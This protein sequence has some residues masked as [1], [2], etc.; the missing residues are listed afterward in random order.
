[1]EHCMNASIFQKNGFSFDRLL[2]LIALADAGSI[3]M[4]AGRDP[5]RQSQ[6]SRQLKELETCFG[7][8]L[9]EHKGRQV[10]LTP[11]GQKLVALA[12]QSFALL[13]GFASEAQGQ[14]I[15]YRLGAGDALLHWALAPVLPGITHAFPR[16]R[17][18][19]ESMET[20]K[21]I[22]AVSTGVLDFGVVRA[23]AALGQLEHR[24]IGSLTYRLYVPVP[25]MPDGNT[26]SVKSLLTTLPL[27]FL[28]G[29]GEYVRLLTEL[30]GN[31]LDAA[32]TYA[33]L[34]LVCRAVAS[35]NCIGVLPTLARSELPAKSFYEMN[36]SAL[37]K[38]KRPLALVYHPRILCVRDDGER[39]VTRLAHEIRARLQA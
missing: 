24:P 10:V 26:D 17:F 25:L 39:L 13:E 6:Y 35:A 20:E 3:A 37:Q 38:M 8:P 28:R 32:I 15:V 27:A 33:T 19:C 7:V 18:S 36:A 2:T 9:T 12:R 11:A 30:A 21:L 31:P 34:P 5:V 29:N 4:A 23:N 14:P 22:E 1:M 16:V